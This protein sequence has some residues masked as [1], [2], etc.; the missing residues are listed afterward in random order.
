MCPHSRTSNA[1]FVTMMM[2][3]ETP[4]FGRARPRRLKPQL[5]HHEVRLRGLGG[6]AAVRHPR[7]CASA[8]R[9]IREGGRRCDRPPTGAR[10]GTLPRCRGRGGEFSPATTG[11]SR[12]SPSPT[13][14]VGEGRG[15]GPF[16]RSSMPFPAH[17]IPNSLSPQT[18]SPPGWTATRA[19]RANQPL[20]PCCPEGRAA[21]F[22]PS[23]G[24]RLPGFTLSWQW[25][26]RTPSTSQV[27]SEA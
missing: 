14:F 21:R 22:T 16:G 26:P 17:R 6:P 4:R 24:G 19:A 3:R 7:T 23:T 2:V 8:T 15:G 1:R 27:S 9:T 11:F 5:Q 18:K 20:P 13:Q 10:R 25:T 12:R